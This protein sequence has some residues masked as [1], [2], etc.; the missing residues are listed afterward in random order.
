MTA[1]D[2]ASHALDATSVAHALDTDLERGLTTAQAAGRLAG[3]GP[4]VL[5]EE[6]R[7]PKWRRFARQFTDPL[8]MLL[9]AATVISAVVWLLEGA[10]GLP[11]DSIVIMAIVLLN[12]TLG[13]VQEERAEQAIAA[14]RAMTEVTATVVRD[15]RLGSVPARDLVPGDLTVLEAGDAIAA[16]ARLVRTVS[17]STGEGALTGE[18]EPVSKG[19]DP[20]A[21]DAALGDR[22][23]MVFSGTVVTFGRGAAVVT[24]TGMATELGRIA[25]LLETV[26]RQETPLQREIARI[27][28]VLG[29]AVVAVAVV[30][31]ASILAVSEVEGTAAL[32]DVMLIGVS[33]AVA[34][35]PEGLATIL[36]VVLA[37][38][39]QRMAR[40][41]AIVRRLS[42]VETLGAATTICTDK[43]GTLTRNEMTVR[44]AVTP[45]G[46]AVLSGTGYQPVGDLTDPDGSPLQ[47]TPH[48]SD[49]RRLLLAAALASNA[50][51][52]ER[53]GTWLA[54]GDPT[55][56]ALVAAARKVGETPDEAGAR[57]PRIDEVPFSSERKLMSTVHRD[58][59][60]PD[61]LRVVT[62]G[63]PDVL[64][65]RCTHERLGDE[66]V[67]L[68]PERRVEIVAEVEDLAARAMRTLAVGEG[69]VEAAGYDGPG[70]H[71][72]RDLV[73]LGT[74][75][76]I[77]P[78]RE[79]AAAAVAAAKGAGVR[80]MMI[81]GD[82]P[83]TARAIAAE[84]GIA[85]ADAPVAS[86]P[87]LERMDDRTLD[88]TVGGVSV[89]ARV[90]PE[91]KLR[92]VRSLQGAGHVVAMTGDGVNDAPALKTADIGVAM[93]I[94]GT[95][96]SKEASD[97]V[98]TDDDFATIV[99]AIEEGRSIFA[100][101]RKFIR[102]LLSSNTGEVMTMFL[103]IVFAGVLG[104]RGGSDG[105]VTP[106]LATQIL[107][108]NLLTD[109]APALA[110]GMDPPDA[111][112]M[113]RPPRR[114]TARVVDG[115]M[116]VSIALN[117][118][119]MAVATLLVLDLELPGGL[120]EGSMSERVAR[121]MAFT[122]LVLA[123]L[124]NVFNARSDRRSAFHDLFSNPL[125]WGAVALSAFLQV[126]VVY[127]PFL[128]TAFGTEPLTGAQ[129]GVTIV[130]ASAVLWVSEVR[131]LIAARLG[132][133][134]RAPSSGGR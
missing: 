100:N 87:E 132:A 107:W 14:L 71:L 117:G 51:I 31:I 3:V 76:I 103:G 121:T 127:V 69:R 89:F 49:I 10:H 62:K 27:G 110:V 97:M 98:L 64:V 52:E 39:V 54:Q 95:D 114:R 7:E 72:E 99:A 77:D 82:H 34:A 81:T 115:P 130:A 83:V 12:S 84:V 25:G 19:V 73:F 109:A 67:E 68:T 29:V 56:G 108:I 53:D 105:I 26:E 90:S 38:G 128:N 123:Q 58:A 30:V 11:I 15:G 36:T 18:S 23:D 8:V 104:L 118:V 102:Y 50:T 24:A 79:E 92:I 60:T 1:L 94:A 33:L 122:T 70:E 43:T 91:H 129:W 126:A 42:A 59:A 93:G 4:N 61:R 37:L 74:L 16:D 80:V 85:S 112:R 13:Y 116:W 35:V 134:R 101:I 86:G 5:R 55:E 20:V 120:L 88:E 6:P 63:A 57:F 9:L 48:A 125:L 111:R 124:V 113:L 78:P 119:A 96:V 47:V 22:T 75:G 2:Q 41:H 44:E 131:K 45:S 106:L 40:R 32:I 66:V 133:T 65:A 28:R 21:G 46:S 17:L